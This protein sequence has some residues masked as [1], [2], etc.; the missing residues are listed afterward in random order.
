MAFLRGMIFRPR[1]LQTGVICLREGP[2]GPE[3]L[4]VRTLD[5]GRWIIPKGWPMDGKTLAE[6]AEIEAWEE[7]GATGRMMPGEFARIPSNK[8]RNDGLEVPTDLAI[9]VM[10]DTQLTE[11]YPEAGRRERQ[12]WPIDLAA[13]RA[14]VEALGEVIGTLRDRLDGGRPAG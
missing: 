8:R 13:R 14:D 3:V 10:T 1:A 7:A 4:L 9:F 5:T 11:D 6:A 2:Q 12:M